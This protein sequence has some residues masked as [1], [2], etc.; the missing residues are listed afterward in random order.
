MV[1]VTS[2]SGPGGGAQRSPAVLLSGCPAIRLSSCPVVR[3][4]GCPAVRLSGCPAL[5][6]PQRTGNGEPGAQN[7]FQL[8]APSPD[9]R[10][11]PRSP[12][13]CPQNR[14]CCP[15]PPALS[16]ARPLR[17]PRSAFFVRF[18]SFPLPPLFFFLFLPFYFLY[19][20]SFN[21]PFNSIFFL[22]SFVV[23]RW[24]FFP[25]LF[26]PAPRRSRY[27]RDGP[28]PPQ[29]RT[30]RGHSSPRP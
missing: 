9:R 28:R 27:F 7:R 11:H 22:F 25:A 5:L 24:V 15:G 20:Y 2:T 16:R 30:F 4:S 3:L 12:V 23:L 14:G 29:A 26:S 17:S 21:S 1:G 6:Q 10:L 18:I 8:P 19:S 13:R